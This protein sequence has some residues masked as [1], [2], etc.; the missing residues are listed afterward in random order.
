MRTNP[1]EGGSD[2][3]VFLAAGVPSLLAWH[4][5]DWFYHASLDR[6]DKTSPAEMKHVGVSVAATALVL[7]GATAADAEDVVRLLEGAAGLRLALE[8]KQ[9]AALV[10]AAPDKA[11][12]QATEAAVLAAWR[13]WYAEA[14]RSVRRRCRPPARRRTWSGQ[15]NAASA[16]RLDTR[17]TAGRS[18]S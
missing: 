12:A 9:G 7:A 15:R 18:R 4:F 6:P 2:H 1:Y 11:A 8:T 14:L 5:P 10:A 3:S 17:E 13:K 16:E